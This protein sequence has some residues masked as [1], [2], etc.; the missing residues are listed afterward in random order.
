MVVHSKWDISHNTIDYKRSERL[1]DLCYKVRTSEGVRYKFSHTSK[2]LHM[3]RIDKDTDECF[4]GRCI[5]DNCIDFGIAICHTI[6][7]NKM[8]QVDILEE[9]DSSVI[10]VLQSSTYKSDDEIAGVIND[11]TV[12]DT[13]IGITGVNYD[14][15]IGITGVNEDEVISIVDR[16]KK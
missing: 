11:N 2:G 1:E 12:P 14:T 13:D 4:F 7:S 8:I 10:G 15:D 5:P 3:L 9:G 6:L 16:S